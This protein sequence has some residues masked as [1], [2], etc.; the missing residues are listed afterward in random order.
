MGGRI[1]RGIESRGLMI[2]GYGAV[3]RREYGRVGEKREA[4]ESPSLPKEESVESGERAERRLEVNGGAELAEMERREIGGEEWHEKVN[5]EMVSAA[6]AGVSDYSSKETKRKGK[7]KR[8]S[9][10]AADA[11]SEALLEGI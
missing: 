7:G 3:V 6:V 1:C 2:L 4:K 5:G 8:R 11:S 10:K 9:R